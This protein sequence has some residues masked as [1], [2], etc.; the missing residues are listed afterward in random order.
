MTPLATEFRRTFNAE[1]QIVLTHLQK[2]FRDELAQQGHTLTGKMR[3]SI[4]Y[5]LTDASD[6]IVASMFF[7]D[8]GFILEN[9]VAANKIP[10]SG[11]T[12]AASSKYILG[13]IKYFK[14]RLGYDEKNA[15]IMAFK[16]AMT[17]RKQGMPSINSYGFSKNGRRTGF[18]KQ[19]INDNEAYI[20]KL[21]DIAATNNIIGYFDTILDNTA[22]QII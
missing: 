17:H 20:T 21:I 5:T 2:A 7:E 6:L 3:D 10:F 4:N 18:V 13:L 9:G 14:L 19:A 22:K 15:K 11:R 12:G 8:Y 1:I 16:T